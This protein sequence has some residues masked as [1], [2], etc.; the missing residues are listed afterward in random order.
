M[1]TYTSASCGRN[2]MSPPYLGELPSHVFRRT[3]PCF[4]S[5]PSWKCFHRRMTRSKLRKGQSHLLYSLISSPHNGRSMLSSWAGPCSQIH[6]RNPFCTSF[7]T[8]TGALSPSRA[9][10][11]WLVVT[12]CNLHPAEIKLTLV[13]FASK[14]YTFRVNQFRDFCLRLLM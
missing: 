3:D 8:F 14:G 5:N 7:F 6:R 4:P 10:W 1:S 2:P 9:L 11:H 13:V 12:G